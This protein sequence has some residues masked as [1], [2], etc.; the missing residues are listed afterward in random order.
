MIEIKKRKLRA[1]KGMTLVEML[2]AS[3]LVLIMFSIGYSLYTAGV[4]G[5]LNNANA[6][7]GESNV[8]IAVDHISRAFRK[9]NRFSVEGNI[10]EIDDDIYCLKKNILY[11]NMNQLAAGIS[12]FT[13]SKPLPHQVYIKISSIPNDFGESFTLEAWLTVRRI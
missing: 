4:K 11:V 10:L 7:D 12:E 8:R 5:F 3:S 13:V 1:N 6:L 9:A 2:V